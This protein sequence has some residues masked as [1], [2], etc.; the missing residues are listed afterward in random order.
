[1]KP[2]ATLTFGCCL[3]AAAHAGPVEVYRT[4]EQYCPRDRPTVARR[5]TAAEAVERA[6]SLLPADFCGPT[7][8]VSGCSFEPEWALESWRVYAVQ[9]KRIAGREDSSGL[10]HSYVILDAVGNC[11]ANIPGT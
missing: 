4:G 6:R 2:R 11:L 5:I 9:Y 8:F 3:V 10:D 1:M 7:Y